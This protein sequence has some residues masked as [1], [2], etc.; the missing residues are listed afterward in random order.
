[1]YLLDSGLPVKGLLGPS[2]AILA[3]LA[4]VAWRLKPARP[5]ASLLTGAS[6][7]QCDRY[8]LDSV[9]MSPFSVL[10]RLTRALSSSADSRLVI[11]AGVGGGG[12]VEAGGEG[13]EDQKASHRDNSRRPPPVANFC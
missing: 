3:C 6:S 1:M 8:G 7:F 12:R 4:V 10:T 5:L 9:L 13:V 2:S 11:M